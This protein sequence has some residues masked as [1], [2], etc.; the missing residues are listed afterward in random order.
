MYEVLIRPKVGHL[1]AIQFML[2]LSMQVGRSGL[3]FFVTER[4]GLHA[5]G[6]SY[7]ISYTGV[8]GAFNSGTK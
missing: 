8:I 2:H 7:I 5:E 4:F 3:Q 6:F 1:L